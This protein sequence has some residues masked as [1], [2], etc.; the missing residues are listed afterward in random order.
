[1]TG[2]ANAVKGSPQGLDYVLN[3]KGTAIEICRNGLIGVQGL[4]CLMSF[5]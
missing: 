1:M 5:A 4:R 2:K 3:D